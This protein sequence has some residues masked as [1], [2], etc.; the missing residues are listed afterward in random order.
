MKIFFARHGEYQNPDNVIPYQLPGF[1][2]S[3]LGKQQAKLQ[4]DKLQ[5]EKIRSLSCSPIE[6]CMETASIIGQAIHLHPNTYP[7][8]IERLED[9]TR[10]SIVSRMAEFVG[11]LKLMSKNSSHLIVSHGDPITYYLSHVT[12]KSL[13]LIPMGG[14]V[15]LDYS[16]SGSPK[17]TE[18]I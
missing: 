3:E 15:M 13:Q 5:G 17:Y 16:Q 12:K 4:G 1:P 6:R 18:I 8:L 10:E 14:L 2:L 11:K 9:E 7:E